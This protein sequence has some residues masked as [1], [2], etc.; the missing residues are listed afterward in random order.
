[1]ANE[2][3]MNLLMKS[4][5]NEDNDCLMDLDTKTIQKLKMICYKN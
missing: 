5:E 2:L 1:M 3:N 4:L